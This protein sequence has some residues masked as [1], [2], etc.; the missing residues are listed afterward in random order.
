[1]NLKKVYFSFGFFVVVI[2]ATSL[3]YI[4][5]DP[6]LA[7]IGDLQISKSEAEY[8]DKIIWLENPNEKRQMGLYQLIQSSI[9]QQILMNHGVDFPAEIIQQEAR[10]MDENSKNPQQL[11][12]IKDIFG[13]KTKAYAK[14]FVLPTL[15]NR[16][17]YSDFFLNDESVHSITLQKAKDFT[18]AALKDPRNFHQ[19]ALEKSY[20][21]KKLTVSL[22]GEMDWGITQKSRFLNQNQKSDSGSSLQRYFNPSSLQ[23][24]EAQKW[25][26]MTADLKPNQVFPMPINHGASLLTIRYLG[27]MKSKHSFEYVQFEKLD[28]QK[29]QRAEKEKI[30]VM[31]FDSSLPVPPGLR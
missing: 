17:I 25:L 3:F 18:E 13:K 7:E 28:Y 31:I 6:K 5:H 16:M 26:S 29:W 8:R 11:Q 27:Q 23:F 10:R 2:F 19:L 14:V 15:V 30:E 22:K 24:E 1:M 20:S 9:N 4:F 21:V 12:K